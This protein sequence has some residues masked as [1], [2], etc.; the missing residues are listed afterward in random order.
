MALLVAT[1]VRVGEPLEIKL[2]EV[3]LKESAIYI[4]DKGDRERL[5][6]LPDRLITH[7]L[8]D[9]LNYRAILS[10]DHTQIIVNTRGSRSPAIYSPSDYSD[11]RKRQAC[12]SGHTSLF[13]HTCATYFLDAGLDMR[14]VQKLLGHQS[15]TTTEIYTHVS[16]SKLKELIRSDFMRG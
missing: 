5:V 10:P 8:R 11:Q 4:H 2:E 1:G 16:K 7:L 13:R 6:F 3:N 14:Y 12:S 15:V 9:Y